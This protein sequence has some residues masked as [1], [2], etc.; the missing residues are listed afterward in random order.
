[1]DLV[2]LS[3][4]QGKLCAVVNDEPVHVSSPRLELL[5]IDPDSSKEVKRKLINSSSC[6]GSNAFELGP[7]Y[8]LEAHGTGCT[9]IYAVGFYT[10][11][12]AVHR[13]LSGFPGREERE[14]SPGMF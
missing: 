11:S 2:Q 14:L 1:M 13:Y 6:C 12:E 5:K 4:N 7:G 10:I 3:N 8:T 9:R